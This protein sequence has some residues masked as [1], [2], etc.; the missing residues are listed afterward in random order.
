VLEYAPFAKKGIENRFRNPSG[1]IPAM[2]CTANRSCD[3]SPIATSGS[4]V[5]SH[6]SIRIVG[7]QKRGIISRFCGKLSRKRRFLVP[8]L[9][10]N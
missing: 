5:C 2:S 6:A 9:G 4:V 10:A 3:H 8:V 1:T 7:A